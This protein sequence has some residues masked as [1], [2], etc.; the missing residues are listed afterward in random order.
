MVPLNRTI[1]LDFSV[2]LWPLAAVR[3]KWAKMAAYDPKQILLAGGDFHAISICALY[4]CSSD[5][6]RS[7]WFNSQSIYSG[8]NNRHTDSGDRRAAIV[9]RGRIED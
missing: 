8:V 2:R 7:R 4:I 6:M 5:W 3:G 1:Q 9:W